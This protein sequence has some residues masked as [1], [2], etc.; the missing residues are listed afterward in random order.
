LLVRVEL[1]GLIC[2]SFAFKVPAPGVA[3][4]SLKGLSHLGSDARVI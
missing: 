4:L 3:L 1:A 2:G